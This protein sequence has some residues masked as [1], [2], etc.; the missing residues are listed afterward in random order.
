M[1]IKFI[2]PKYQLKIALLKQKD[3]SSKTC[4]YEK[5]L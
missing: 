4:V 3:S 2:A 1:I 5:L